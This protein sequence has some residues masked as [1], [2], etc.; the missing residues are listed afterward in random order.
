MTKIKNERKLYNIVVNNIKKRR[1]LENQY[2]DLMILTN[3][4]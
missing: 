1:I 2:I 4:I 3:I